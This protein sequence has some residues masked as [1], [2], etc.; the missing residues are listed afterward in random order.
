MHNSLR[1]DGK[2]SKEIIPGFAQNYANKY[3]TKSWNNNLP[4][5]LEVIYCARSILN[6]VVVVFI[7]I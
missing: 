7:F 1:I 4:A 2:T 5:K 3:E 6:L